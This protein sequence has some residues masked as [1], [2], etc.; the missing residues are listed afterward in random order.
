VQATPIDPV[1]AAQIGDGQLEGVAWTVLAEEIKAVAVR[2]GL[3]DAGEKQPLERR[4]VGIWNRRLNYGGRVIFGHDEVSGKQR[5]RR[6]AGLGETE[7]R[8]G[9]HPPCS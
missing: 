4:H 7:L 6:S 3:E 5:A 8:D 9:T 1:R 2:L